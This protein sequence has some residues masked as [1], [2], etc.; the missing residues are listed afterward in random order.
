MIRAGFTMS[1]I[2]TA[3]SALGVILL[4]CALASRS[5]SAR[6]YMPFKS[7]NAPWN[8]DKHLIAKLDL[9]EKLWAEAVEDR[10]EM[11]NHMGKDREFP[12]GYLRPYNVWDFAR[13]SF[14]CPHDLERVGKLG[15]GGKVVCGMSRYEKESPG[16]SSATNPAPEL[17]IYSFG[18]NKD[19]SFEAAMME[20]TNA[21][22][23]GYDFS[24][25]G[26]G[27][28]IQGEYASRAHFHKIGIGKETDKTH[29]PPFWSVADLM[30]ENGHDYV[31]IVKMD[32]EGAEFGALTSLVEHTIAHATD[33]KGNLPFGQL[34]LEVH[35]YTDRD[36]GGPKKL[37]QWVNW[38]Q[39][40]E[41][42][43][44]RPVNNEDNW[45]GDSIMGKPRFMEVCHSHQKNT[46]LVYLFFFILPSII[47]AIT[48]IF[49]S[50][51]HHDQCQGHGAEQAPLDVK[52]ALAWCER[53]VAFSY[54]GPLPPS[55]SPA[56]DS[57]DH[58]GCGRNLGDEGGGQGGCVGPLTPRG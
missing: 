12:D 23:W 32:I 18:V 29:D 1:K 10:K 26:W 27:K 30:V 41:A 43:G 37:E 11:M 33:G 40:L 51:V 31:D 16:P 6:E 58:I 13:P 34:L 5:D 7:G 25:E 38:F 19:S 44:L 24:V 9:A 42:V 28:E 52:P 49:V 53:L 4:I 8:M 46:Q 2:V 55:P 48:D 21:H 3:A 15:D 35:F 14:F 36:M 17:L 47:S 57:A 50:P 56:P 20:R 54:Q 22:I 45:I 39:S